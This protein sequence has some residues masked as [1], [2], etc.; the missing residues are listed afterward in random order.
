MQNSNIRNSEVCRELKVSA[1]LNVNNA[2]L[3]YKKH[4]DFS[5]RQWAYPVIIDADESNNVIVSINDLVE[6]VIRPSKNVVHVKW[7]APQKYEVNM[8]ASVSIIHKQQEE[9]YDAIDWKLS[10]N[11]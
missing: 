11:E 9:M 8:S 7:N 4:M 3:E 6:G 10:L 1:I 2:V 5:L